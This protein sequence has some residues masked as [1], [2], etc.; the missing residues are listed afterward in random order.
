MRSVLQKLLECSRKVTDGTRDFKG[1]M[2]EIKEVLNKLLVQ[3]NNPFGDSHPDAK[4]SDVITSTST[5]EKRVQTWI[6]GLP[7]PRDETLKVISM[8]FP[9]HFIECI[10]CCRC[11]VRVDVG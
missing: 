11:L 6:E 4:M 8:K 1:Q 2:N 7:G 9:L 10:S 5:F 3:F